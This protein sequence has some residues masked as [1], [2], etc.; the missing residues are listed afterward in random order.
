MQDHPILRGYDL[1]SVVVDCSRGSITAGQF[2]SDVAA[3]A[4]RLPDRRYIV[5]LCSDRYRF[6]VAF[7]AALQREQVTLLPSSEAPESLAKLR[8]EY[9][10]LYIIRDDQTAA[11]DDTSF[12]F[13]HD[14]AGPPIEI[15]P[16]I[17]ADRLAAVLFTSGSTGTPIANPRSWGALVNSTRAAAQKMGVAGLRDA[18]ILGTV[19]HQHSYGLESIVMLSLQNGFAF[20]G[21]RALLPADIIADLAALPAPRILVTTPVHLRS[22]VEY[23]GAVPQLSHIVC[24]TAPLAADMALRAETKFGARLFEIY[25]CSEVGQIAVR[26]TSETEEWSCIDGIA[27]SQRDGE[28]WAAGPSAAA[29]APLNDIIELRSADRFIF[30][31]RK[32]DMINIAGKRSS[33]AFLNHQLNQVPGVRDGVFIVPPDTEAFARLTAYVV[34]PTLSANDILKVLRRHLDPAFLPRPIHF[35]EALPRNALGKLP[36]KA[37]GALR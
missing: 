5:N 37:I 18:H 27:L 13:P 15:A 4:T 24:A 7:M 22:L 12:V 3:L 21:A 25:G 32:A 23:D 29:P 10:D 33:L 2:L 11:T 36:A 8:S 20:H 19:P 9:P 34:A 14:L 1:S 31:G 35:V 28:I 26:R 17:P 30:H 16:T 6:S